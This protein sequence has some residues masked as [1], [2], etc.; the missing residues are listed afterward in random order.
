MYTFF[1][2]YLQLTYTK[3][4]CGTKKL[5]PRFLIPDLCFRLVLLL[6]GEILL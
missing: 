2:R 4:T 6:K 5:D 3:N 1:S